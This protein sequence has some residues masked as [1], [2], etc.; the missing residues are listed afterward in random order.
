MHLTA[1]ASQSAPQTNM[2]TLDSA[3]NA[4][5]T[6][7]DVQKIPETVSAV[8]QTVLTHFFPTAEYVYLL[9]CKTK[10][11]MVATVFAV[12]QTVGA[13]PAVQISVHHVVLSK[14]VLCP[15]SLQ[16]V[17]VFVSVNAEISL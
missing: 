15:T 3:Y 7:F 16:L 2:L 4:L 5:R 1:D 10:L 11:T 14:I 12:Q 6:V 17:V 8:F 13:V 9:A